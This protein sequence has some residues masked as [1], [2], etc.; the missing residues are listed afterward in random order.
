MSGTLEAALRELT[1]QQREAVDWQEGSL[2]VLAGPGSGKTRVLTARIARLLTE[3]PDRAFRILALT[4]TNLAADEMSGRVN[5][6]TPTAERRAVV[7]TF[8]S[9][10][11]QVLQQ[12]GAHLGVS[13]NFTIYSQ[14]V[15]R[16]SL[17][18]EALRRN[19]PVDGSPARYLAAIDRLKSRL[20]PP[21]DAVG[22]FRDASQGEQVAKVYAAYEAELTRANALDFGSLVSKTFELVTTFPAIAESYRRAYAYWLIDEFQDTT[23]GQ[24]R[25]IKAL[26][27]NQ[28]KNVFIVAD[29]DQ[30]IY[31]WNGASFRQIERFR[32]EFNPELIQLPTNYRCPPAIVQAANKLVAHNVQRTANK[33]PLES[34]KVVLRYSPD[35]HVT[36]RRFCDDTAEM[37]GIAAE[38]LALGPDSWGS[39][40]VLAR[41]RKLLEQQQSH[42]QHVSV[43][44]LVAQ[45]RDDFLSAEFKWLQAILIQAIRPLDRRNVEI[46][47]T[48]FNTWHQLEVSAEQI[49]TEAEVSSRG[50]V[51]EWAEEVS[52]SRPDLA[53]FAVAAT[54]LMRDTGSYRKFIDLMLVGFPDGNAG[55][56]DLAEDISAWRELHRSI[57]QT[58]GRD[59]SLEQFL[60]ELALRSKEP[61]IG[62]GTVALMTIHAA[63]GK[64]FD[65]V[66]LVGAAEDILPSFQSLK[67]GAASSQM[68]EERR[69]C[70]VAITR[71]RE[72]LTISFADQ[73]GNWQ[74]RPSRFI[75]EM[76]LSV[77]TSCE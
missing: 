71:A 17:L 63:K 62:P 2:L 5:A 25:L 67:T 29:D 75:D 27:G 1:P 41:T 52:A 24:Y 57:T 21:A 20:I 73:Y 7:G 69:N 16:Q 55:D 77:P 56:H 38:I 12:H 64:E 49:F 72:C 58:L 60:Q 10:C 22:H 28:F 76:G 19:G 42:L 9:F 18:L 47:V 50:F 66:Y 3:S 36:V 68:E 13:T 23:D 44:S 46:F 34:G 32:S 65:H 70:F 45:R 11:M 26:A 37:T 8:H 4:F 59:S 39:T 15:D 40:V 61:P 43:P 33:K 14:E 30:I 48:A 31:Q 51:D 6:L 53:Q 54:S 35:R 74:R